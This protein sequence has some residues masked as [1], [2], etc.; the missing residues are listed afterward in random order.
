VWYSTGNTYVR[1][2]TASN[3]KWSPWTLMITDLTNYT[4]PTATKLKTPIKLWGNDFDGS[5]NISGQLILDSNA[6]LSAIDTNGKKSQILKLSASN[7]L[8]LGGSSAENGFDTYIRG[9]NI[10][11]QCGSTHLDGIYVNDTGNIGIGT[12]DP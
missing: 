10:R 4:A 6:A 8:V 2:Y 1:T 11:I 12:T 7:N 3:D 5:S 9:N